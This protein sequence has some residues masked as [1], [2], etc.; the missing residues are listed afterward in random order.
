[1]RSLTLATSESSPASNFAASLAPKTLQLVVECPRV[2]RNSQKVL[3]SYPGLRVHVLPE[4]L[5]C[6]GLIA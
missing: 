6:S 3:L 2:W 4:V 1:M 5:P